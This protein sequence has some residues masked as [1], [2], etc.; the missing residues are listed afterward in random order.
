MFS[1]THDQATTV[2]TNLNENERMITAT[3]ELLQA[4][5]G[6]DKAKKATRM[7]AV[8]AVIRGGNQEH[9]TLCAQLCR[10]V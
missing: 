6:D 4:H 9:S 3:Q 1:P 10:R 7:R 5:H 2:L 8:K